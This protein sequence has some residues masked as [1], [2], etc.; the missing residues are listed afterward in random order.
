MNEQRYHAKCWM[1]YDGRYDGITDIPPVRYEPPFS[2]NGAVLV[3][4]KKTESCEGC[5]RAIRKNTRHFR[6]RALS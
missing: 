4:S 5:G 6:L 1:S 3:R 2:L